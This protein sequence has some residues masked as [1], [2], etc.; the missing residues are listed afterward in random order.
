MVT[1]DY[2]WLHRVTYSYSG[3]HKGTVGYK[4][5]RIILGHPGTFKE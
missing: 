4:G 2:I 1:V 5:S 3:L